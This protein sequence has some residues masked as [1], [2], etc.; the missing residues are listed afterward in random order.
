M[1]AFDLFLF[2]SESEGFPNVI[3]EA[4]SSSIPY[5]N[6]VLIQEVAK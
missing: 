5:I 2:P 6:F 3:G 1:N 4:M